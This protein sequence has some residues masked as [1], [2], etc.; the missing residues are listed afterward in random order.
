M[1]YR[2]GR[3]L[4]PAGNPELPENARQVM[5]NGPLAN[6]ELLSDLSV[7]MTNSNHRNNIVFSRGKSMSV[8]RRFYMI[9]EK[10]IAQHLD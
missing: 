8:V 9:L 7:G 3:Q 4:Q 2:K 10:K 5:F 6:R 1:R